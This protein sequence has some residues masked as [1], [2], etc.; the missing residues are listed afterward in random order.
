MKRKANDQADNENRS[1]IRRLGNAAFSTV[2]TLVEESFMMYYFNRL[3]TV[4]QQI[5]VRDRI[6]A[7]VDN[8]LLSNERRGR[9]EGT[10]V[11]LLELPQ[12]VRLRI[13][14]FVDEQRELGEYACVAKQ[15][16][17]DLKHPALDHL[18]RWARIV[19]PP[20]TD[21]VNIFAAL[22]RAHDR[23]VFAK[24]PGLLIDFTSGRY[25]ENLHATLYD[26]RH[27]LNSMRLSSVTHLEVKAPVPRDRD[28]PYIKY[29]VLNFLSKIMPKLKSITI[30]ADSG[31]CSASSFTTK[32]KTTSESFR[33]YHSRG[34]L[35]V[36]GYDFRKCT[37]LKHLSL[38]G[39]TFA[40]FNSNDKFL[41]HVRNF[42]EEVSVPYTNLM[43]RRPIPY[44]W[45]REFIRNAPRLRR[46]RTSL[47]VLSSYQIAQ[48]RLDRPDVE[49]IV[50][51]LF[52]K[53][54]RNW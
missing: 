40:R 51:W 21:V 32:C 37:R 11:G 28:F 9:E 27:I 16:L 19:V 47:C 35:R 1:I 53:G 3:P 29:C 10:V 41:W 22:K 36:D 13:L 8:Q 23:G 43:W 54:D 17:A 18:V 52:E 20:D 14:D 44:E 50:A 38:D 15:C 24:I 39:C 5:R 34:H 4:E 49:F 7:E 12:E 2:Q 26:V 33:W 6:N 31:K 46:F 42:I 48:A 45:I 25:H 30:D